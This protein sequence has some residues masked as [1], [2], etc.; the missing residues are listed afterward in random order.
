MDEPL[1]NKVYRSERFD[2]EVVFW[3]DLMTTKILDVTMEHLE[4]VTRRHYEMYLK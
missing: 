2:P 3:K 1:K 4:L